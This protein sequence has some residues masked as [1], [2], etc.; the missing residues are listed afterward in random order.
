LR[1]D[2]MST[3]SFRVQKSISS[4]SSVDGGLRWKHMST[5]LFRLQKSK[6]SQSSVDGGL[7]WDNMFNSSTDIKLVS[8]NHFHLNPPSTEDWDETTCSHIPIVYKN[9]YNPSTGN[10]FHINPPSTEDWDGL[11]HYKIQSRVHSRNMSH[12]AV[13]Y[14]PVG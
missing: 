3:Y 8:V 11:C 12:T 9:Q 4:Q 10:H 2:N 6:S 5:Y 13:D 1:W 7:R 14:I